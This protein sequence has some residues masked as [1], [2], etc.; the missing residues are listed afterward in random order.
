M[1]NLIERQFAK[2]V[3]TYDYAAIAQKQIADHLTDQIQL[4]RKKF[5]KIYEIGAGTGLSTH[6]L[7]KK[8]STEQFIVNDLCLEMEK[9]VSHI[10]ESYS[11]QTWTFLAGN[12]EY[13]PI[14]SG[15]DLV[16]S[17]SSFQWFSDLESFLIK[18]GKN[19]K[20]DSI[21]AFSTFG[22]KNLYECKAVT[23]AGLHYLNPDN[24]DHAMELSFETVYGFEEEITLWFD[25]PLEVIQHMKQT[26][27]NSLGNRK[28]TFDDSETADTIWTPA[29][30]K[31]FEEVYQKEFEKEGKYPLTYHPIYRIGLRKD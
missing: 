9:P 13:L 3:R 4:I 2:S 17:S 20:R 14:P 18:T 23:G 10:F 7:L 27:V 26:G 30:L 25:S 6:F 15:T 21:L 19:L 11:E 1:K 5:V 28:A 29:K 8:L 16:V 31:K 12:A 22:P 24:I